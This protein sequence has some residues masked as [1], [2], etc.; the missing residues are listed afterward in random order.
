MTDTSTSYKNKQDC[1][2]DNIERFI[3]QNQLGFKEKV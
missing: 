1:V 2:F 3:A